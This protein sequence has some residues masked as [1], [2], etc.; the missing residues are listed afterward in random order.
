MTNGLHEV[1]RDQGDQLLVHV[2]ALRVTSATYVLEDLTAG[3]DASDRVLASGAATVDSLS[4][5]LSANSGAG[6][7]AP[8][9]IYVSA[10]PAVVG[11]LYV[12]EDAEGQ[13]ELH[14]IE[15]ATATYVTAAGD[16]SATYLATSSY[17]RGVE[18]RATFPSAVA[19]RAELQEEERPLRVTWTYALAGRTV[20]MR[21][22]VRLLRAGST[23]ESYL[24]RAEATLRE[25]WPEL[26]RAIGA[27]PGALSALV[28]SCARDLDAKLRLRGIAPETFLAGAQGFETLLARCVWRFG[29]R[30]H[31]PAGTDIEAWREDGK[32]DYLNLWKA[33]TQESPGIDTAET[34]RASDQASAGHSQRRRRLIV[35][36]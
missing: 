34:T 25:D 8:R 30:G 21:E 4:A 17:L 24:G 13:Q 22:Q 28:R 10:A 23:I 36:K 2:P 7:V 5:A 32:R 27:H 20:R 1:Y 15:G 19:A 14:R 9:R 6:T 33:T 11:R 29:Q 26:V 16:L 18:I 31:A 12:V 3:E 35:M